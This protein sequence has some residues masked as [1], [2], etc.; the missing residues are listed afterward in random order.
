MNQVDLGYQDWDVQMHEFLSE[1]QAEVFE[2]LASEFE[3]AQLRLL[4]AQVWPFNEGP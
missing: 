3:S 2:I 4:F 1:F